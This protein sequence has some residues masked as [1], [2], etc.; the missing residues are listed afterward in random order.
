MILSYLIV[1]MKNITH[2]LKR[3]LKKYFKYLIMGMIKYN[4]FCRI[5]NNL[6]MTKMMTK[7]SQKLYNLMIDIKLPFLDPYIFENGAVY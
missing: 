6:Y 5:K 4:R 3:W 7:V 1:Q 2:L